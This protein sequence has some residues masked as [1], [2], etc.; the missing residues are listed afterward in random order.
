MKLAGK[1][2]MVIVGRVGTGIAGMHLGDR[3]AGL[4]LGG[5]NRPQAI[6]VDCLR[7]RVYTR[8]RWQ[9]S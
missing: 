4:R 5:V 9:K 6:G 7:C 1:V 8:S 3:L 2:G